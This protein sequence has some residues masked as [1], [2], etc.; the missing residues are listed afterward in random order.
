MKPSQRTPPRDKIAVHTLLFSQLPGEQPVEQLIQ[1]VKA[2]PRQRL[3]D[4]PAI[5]DL[6][7][8]LALQE[9]RKYCLVWLN[10]EGTALAFAFLDPYDNLVLECGHPQ[11]FQGCFDEALTL[12]LEAMRDK[13][14]GQDKLPTLDASCRADDTLRLRALSLSG[15]IKEPLESLAFQRILTIPFPEPALP[16]GFL[17]RSL[18]GEKELDAYVTLHQVAFGSSQM[19]REMR[20]AIMASPEYDPELDLVIEAPGGKLAGFCVCQIFKE[21]N[22]QTGEQIGWTDPIGVHPDYRGRGL[23]KA[24]MLSGFALLK[25]KGMKTVRLDTSSENQA[26]ISLARSLGFSEISRRLWFSRK[27]E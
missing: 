18:R 22:L 7:E 16:A 13:H 20:Q 24:L 3:A 15:F 23:A 12:C 6:R 10:A 25:E 27:L 21:E 4:Y 19:T 14:R 9:V 11:I 5:I 26:M 1:L 2:R 17:I 8:L